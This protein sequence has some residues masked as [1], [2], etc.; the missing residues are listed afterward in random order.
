ME[1]KVLNQALKVLIS[2]LEKTE[3]FALEQAP[4]ICKEMVK[5]KIFDE[6]VDLVTQS[7]LLVFFLILGTVFYN[8]GMHYEPKSAWDSNGGFIIGFG[9]GLP[10]LLSTIVLGFI[11][12]TIKHLWY[13]KNCPK[14]FLLREFRRLLK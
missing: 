1:K 9:V 2:K 4:E 14:L 7:L 8:L 12:Q 10:G 5:E 3:K 11:V 6:S 13:V